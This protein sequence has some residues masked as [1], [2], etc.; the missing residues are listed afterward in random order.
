MHGGVLAVILWMDLLLKHKGLLDRMCRMSTCE[1]ELGELLNFDERRSEL[2]LSDFPLL[3][4]SEGRL[5]YYERTKACH[6][7]LI[8][9]KICLAQL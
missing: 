4:V 2:S 9:R 6:G 8:P 7:S 5:V 3:V 1:Y